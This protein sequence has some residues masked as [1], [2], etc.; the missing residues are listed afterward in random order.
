V[1]WVR[2]DDGFPRH[3]KVRRL[4]PV[5]FVLHVSA[6]CWSAEQLTD[7]MILDH[8]L[9]DVSDLSPKQV[10]KSVA[11]LLGR[12]L[13]EAVDGA[14]LIHDYLDYNPSR[15]DV[16]KEREA[17]KARQRRWLES[18]KGRARDA[19]LDASRDASRDAAPTP[20]PTPTR[21]DPLGSGSGRVGNS[22]SATRANGPVDN[23]RP[24]R[25]R[26]VHDRCANP[27]HD[28][29]TRPDGVC[30]GCEADRKARAG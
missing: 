27:D 10:A 14:Y 2:L 22:R 23:S 11:E 3:P 4:S 16:E 30:P 7:G 12:G 24:P 19:S 9:H 20:T 21:P 1:S 26:V 6:M 25:L 13:W 15:A 5:A 8:Q 29:E 18:K 28:Y 17:K